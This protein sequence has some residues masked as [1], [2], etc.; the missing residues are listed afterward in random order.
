MEEMGTTFSSATRPGPCSTRIVHLFALRA[1]SMVVRAHK[2][3][4]M[5][6]GIAIPMIVIAI[7]KIDR[8]MVTA[9]GFGR[10][11]LCRYVLMRPHLR[12]TGDEG[13]MAPR[14]TF[15]AM[16]SSVGAAPE[17]GYPRAITS[18]VLAFS[19]VRSSNWKYCGMLARSKR[20]QAHPSAFQSA[21]VDW[22]G[23]S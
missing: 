23:L 10:A 18:N 4:T 12:I 3:T 5:N 8:F 7:E 21:R 9:M 14:S 17:R 22:Y 16:K 15:P 1:P 11:A 19:S 6:E 13:S 20:V 2:M